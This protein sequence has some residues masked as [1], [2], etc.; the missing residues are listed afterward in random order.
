MYSKT[1]GLTFLCGKGLILS[2][3]SSSIRTISPFSTSLI[4]LAPIISNAQVSDAT[5]N[6][7]LIF[8]LLVVLCH[9]GL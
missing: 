6:F 5:H 1:Q 4:N 2:N 7:F 9:K 3:L 8:Q